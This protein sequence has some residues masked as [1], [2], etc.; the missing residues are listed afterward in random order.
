MSYEELYRR[1]KQNGIAVALVGIRSGET[2]DFLTL[3]ITSASGVFGLLFIANMHYIFRPNS[4][5]SGAQAG[6]TRQLLLWRN[7]FKL[8]RVFCCSLTRVRF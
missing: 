2:K 3:S 4:P 6:L 8:V 5:S 7:L 1:S